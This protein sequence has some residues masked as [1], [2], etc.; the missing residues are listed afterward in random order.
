MLSLI[1]SK[2]QDVHMSAFS[3][4]NELERLLVQATT[5]MAARPAFYRAFLD[6]PLLAICNVP[7][8]QADSSGRAV[9]KLEDVQS[10][11]QMK[12][13]Q[14]KLVIPV[15]S[16]FAS[17][18]ATH[19]GRVTCVQLKGR[20]LL[21][22]LGTEKPIVLNPMS[23]QS[24]EFTPQELADLQDGTLFKDPEHRTYAPDAHV[25][26]GLPAGYPETLVDALRSLFTRYPGYNKSL[27]RDPRAS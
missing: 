20:E 25:Q 22:L 13:A 3:P 23:E 18:Q 4:Q 7:G 16:S 17:L 6:S 24:K 19:A 15:F 11:V 9:A 10:V 5:D 2:G 14:G 1:C 12:D 8:A 26:P 27:P 21:H